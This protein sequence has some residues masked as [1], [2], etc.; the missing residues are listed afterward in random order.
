MSSGSSSRAASQCVQNIPPFLP[1][2]G[3]LPPNS[4][5]SP[6]PHHRQCCQPVRCAS[7]TTHSLT[8]TASAAL[9]HTLLCNEKLMWMCFTSTNYLKFCLWFS[10]YN[11]LHHSSNADSDNVSF[12]ELFFPSPAAA[13]ESW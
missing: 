6:Q 8:H 13:D 3:P 5:A 4:I 7:L 2:T 12:G 9:T 10:F 1:A 11:L